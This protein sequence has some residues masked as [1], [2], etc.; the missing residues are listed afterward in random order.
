MCHPLEN[1][2]ARPT[3]TDQIRTPSMGLRARRQPVVTAERRVRRIREDV[4]G[5]IGKRRMRVNAAIAPVD[6]A[7]WLPSASGQ[8]CSAIT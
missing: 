6:R 7:R 4:A 2:A 8:R 3:L 1:D 5:S